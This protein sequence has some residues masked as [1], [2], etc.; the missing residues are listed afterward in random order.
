[1]QVLGRRGEGR[2]AGLT[3]PSPVSG[4]LASGQLKDA[5]ARVGHRFGPSEKQENVASHRKTLRLWSAEDRGLQSERD[6]G[7]DCRG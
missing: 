4:L 2:L 1:M 3:A 5:H 7:F 6:A